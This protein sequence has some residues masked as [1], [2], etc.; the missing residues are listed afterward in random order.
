MENDFE[1]RP[2]ETAPGWELV[3]RD[4]F[5]GPELDP[6][7]WTFDTGGHGWGNDELQYY[8]DRPENARIENGALLIEARREDYLGRPYTSAR[9]KTQGRGAW[10][11]GRIVAR[12]QLPAGQGVW[13]AFWMLG[14]NFDRV[15]WPDCG[16]IVIMENRG[17]E[18]HLIHGMAHGPGYSGGGGFGAAHQLAGAPYAAGYHEF[19]I[20]WAPEGIRWLVDRTPYAEL[21]PSAVD[22]PWVF[23]QPFFILINVAV[24]GRWPGDPDETTVFPQVMRLDYVR[25][26]RRAPHPAA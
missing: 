15:G 18:P 7:H 4:E 11:F 19:A 9:L 21:S 14:D 25:V 22:G 20:E 5:D 23:D 10:Q 12:I 13:P 16:E 24:G 2:D 17:R 8:T 6:E 3:W 1:N 26:Y